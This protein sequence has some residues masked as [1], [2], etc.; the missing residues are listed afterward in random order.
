MNTEYILQI[1]LRKIAA[2]VLGSSM[3]LSACIQAPSFFQDVTPTE[4]IISTGKAT[5]VSLEPQPTVS[6]TSRPTHMQAAMLPDTKGNANCTYSLYYWQNHPRDW[7]TDNIII[8][9]LSYTKEEALVII[10]SNSE[11][12]TSDTLKH[13]FAAALN[14]LKGADPAAIETEILQISDWL[15]THPPGVKLSDTESEQGKLYADRLEAFNGGAIGP[16]LCADEPSTPTPSPTLTE[17]P[18]VTPTSRPVLPT[19]TPT[20]TERARPQPPEKPEETPVPGATPSPP[21]EPS[22]TATVRPGATQT[23]P[24]PADTEEPTPTSAPSEEPTES[25]LSI[26]P[27]LPDLPMLTPSP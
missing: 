13:F 27:T 20:A 24:P 19:F 16:G 15:N 5:R 12:S 3:L 4:S 8:G 6:Q 21:A 11:D 22:V 1:S 2:L 10:A 26:I 9:R 7:L 14:I 17:T 25:S 23:P 18:T